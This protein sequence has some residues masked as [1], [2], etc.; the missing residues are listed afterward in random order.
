MA[1]A[2]ACADL[3]ANAVRGLVLHREH[4][5]DDG[6]RALAAALE[7]NGSLTTLLQ[8]CFKGQ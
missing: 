3:R 6:A 7:Q 8:T 5:G 4:I 2:T 1:L